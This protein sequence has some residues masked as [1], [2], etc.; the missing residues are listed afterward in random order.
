MNLNKAM[1]IGNLTRD[2]EIRKT[3]NGKSVASFSVATSYVWASDAGVKQEE[4]EYHNIVA[5]GK[6]ADICQQY[7]GKG[8]KVYVEGR[9]KTRDWV[10]KDGVKRIRTE[11]IA[12]NMIML[13]KAPAG[14]SAPTYSAESS[15]PQSFSRPAASQDVD[16]E[17]K[18]EDIPF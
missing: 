8:R 17:V 18:L 12:E 5:W 1:V 11:I 9:L 3:A 15:A 16:E 4:V 2:P 14:G 7:L 10:G 13:D 6:L